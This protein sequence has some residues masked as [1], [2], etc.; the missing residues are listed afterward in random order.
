MISNCD[1][2]RIENYASKMLEDCLNNNID[3]QTTKTKIYRIVTNK[4]SV[5]DNISQ[6]WSYVFHNYSEQGDMYS[7]AA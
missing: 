6:L 7:E 5:I 3:I 1:K 4:K 2:E